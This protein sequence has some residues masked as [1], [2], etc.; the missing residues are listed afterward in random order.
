MERVDLKDIETEV[1]KIVDDSSLFLTPEQTYN[2]E[3]ILFETILKERLLQQ[4]NRRQIILFR[5]F[6]SGA[7]SLERAVRISSVTKNIVVD[8]YDTEAFQQLQNASYLVTEGD[9][10][11]LSSKGIGLAFA[12]TRPFIDAADNY[13]LKLGKELGL[14]K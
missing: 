6:M 10:C 9:L 7:V 8:G 5:T 13:R 2:L 1:K 14:D 12:V 3:G 4:Y 11:Y